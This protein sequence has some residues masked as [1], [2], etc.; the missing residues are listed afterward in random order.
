MAGLKVEIVRADA[1]DEGAW[2]EWRAILADTPALNSPY[3]RPTF[4]QIAG[5]ISPEAAVAVF[6]RDGRTV[7][8]FPHQ[9][10]GGSIQPLAA[11]MNDYHGVIARDGTVQRLRVLSG[12]P[13]LVKAALDAVTRWRYTPTLLNGTPVEVIAP[14]EVNFVLSR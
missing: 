6:T 11:P 10:R 3:F 2:A 1:L 8:F 9:R 14:I 13:L 4:T 12:H 7:G 5:A